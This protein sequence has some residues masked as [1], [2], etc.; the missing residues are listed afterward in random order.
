VDEQARGKPVSAA[1][2]QLEI[3]TLL[4]DAPLD[5]R[6]LL[7][8]LKHRWARPQAPPTLYV[9]TC[10]LRTEASCVFTAGGERLGSQVTCTKV[11]RATR[12]LAGRLAEYAGSRMLGGSP[13]TP[14]SLVLRAVIYGDGPSMLAERDVQQIAAANGSLLKRFDKTGGRLECSNEAYAGERVVE[15]IC[16]FARERWLLRGR[17]AVG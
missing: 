6:V 8:D 15:A 13:I 16:G 14:G 12:S 2:F 4:R 3:G 10:E 7:V 11:G 9:L 17:Q 1:A 5:G